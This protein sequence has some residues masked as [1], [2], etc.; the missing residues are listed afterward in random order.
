MPGS[1][2]MRVTDWLRFFLR[3]RD[4]QAHMRMRTA[5]S[6]SISCTLPTFGGPPT[7]PRTTRGG[8][9][10]CVVPT[11]HSVPASRALV[12][13]P[14][15]PR[16][17]LHAKPHRAASREAMERTPTPKPQRWD[18]SARKPLLSSHKRG[19]SVREKLELSHWDK[20]RLHRRFPWKFAFHALLIIATSTQVTFFSFMPLTPLLV[21]ADPLTAPRLLCA[22]TADEC[23]GCAL[24]PRLPSHVVLHVFSR[25]LRLR[26]VRAAGALLVRRS[27]CCC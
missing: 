7:T 14:A 22:G 8:A 9:R 12:R 21:P 15:P 1:L 13:R 18:Q 20:W 17:P 24:L 26:G 23:A 10:A 19:M 5:K 16:D 2:A 4:W 6:C 27:R 11:L 25:G 3:A